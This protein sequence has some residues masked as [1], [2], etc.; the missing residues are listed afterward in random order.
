MNKMAATRNSKDKEFLGNSIQNV[1][2]KNVYTIK[3]MRLISAN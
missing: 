3:E 2:G 1:R